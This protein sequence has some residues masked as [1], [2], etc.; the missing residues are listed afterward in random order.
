METIL[1]QLEA[2]DYWLWRHLISEMQHE[3]TKSQLVR[4]K[5][6]VMEKELEIARM[7]SQMYKEV[8][9]QYDANRDLAKKAYEEYRA[10]LEQKLGFELKDCVV[11]EVT[12]EVKRFEEK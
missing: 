4:T 8:I 1:G 10:S 5:A 6:A 2:K 12:F 7:K 9:K 11:D 3:E